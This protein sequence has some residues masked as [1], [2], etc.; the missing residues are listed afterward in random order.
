MKMPYR[1]AYQLLTDA[2]AVIGRRGGLQ[3]LADRLDPVLVA[4]RLDEADHDFG[5]R[6]SSPLGKN[7]RLEVRRT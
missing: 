2:R 6:S 4:A 1:P 5:R 3:H 7:M